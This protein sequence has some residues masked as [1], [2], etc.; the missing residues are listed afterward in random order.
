[1]L[2]LVSHMDHPDTQDQLVPLGAGTQR[3]PAQKSKKTEQIYINARP[4]FDSRFL[5][6]LMVG[7][8]TIQTDLS[9]K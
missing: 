5:N 3:G 8:N 7:F 4:G 2:L 9:E 6:I 1:M